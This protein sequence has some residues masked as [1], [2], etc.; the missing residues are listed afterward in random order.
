MAEH[1]RQ[2][3][4]TP[5]LDEIV[6]Y[7]KRTGFVYPSSEI[8]G[9]FAGVYDYG[10]RGVELINNIKGEWW[11][12]VVRR[13]T[14][15]V[16]LDASIFMHPKTWEAS[17]HVENFSDPLTECRSCNSRLR[18][19]HML[20]GIGV[21]ADDK[22][23][24][25]EITELFDEHR[26]EISCPH[27]DAK[28]FT[29]VRQF[30]LLV[31]SNMGNFTGDATKDPVWLRGE[32]CQGIY[33][34]YNN[35]VNTSRVQVPFGIAQIGKAF[36]NEITARQFIF[37]TRE[38]EQMENQRF[39]HPDREM[40]EYERLRDE[41]MEYYTRRLGFNGLN[42]QWKEHDKLAFYANAAW[43]IEYRYPFGFSE[44]EGVHAR[45]NYDLTQHSTHSGVDLSYRDPRTNE[46][47]IPHVIES[48][49]GVGRTALAALTDAY[50]VEELQSGDSRT[51][52]KLHPNLAP[53]K[54][55]V[56]PLVRNKP[57]IVGMAKNIFT[58]ISG[59]FA[60]EFD[61][62]G[63]TGKR[64]RR[65]DEIGTPFAITVDHESVEDGTV[66]VRHRDTMQ[67]ERVNASQ[68]ED[69]IRNGLKT[70]F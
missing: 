14:D 27:C 4:D 52:L 61:D 69:Y 46:R 10:P 33:V 13:R 16:G 58:D 18:V 11:K 66:T 15:T 56:F 20:E 55:A 6:G 5:S 65:Q 3:S 38:F 40:E 36:R 67:Q 1:E 57:E 19:D 63:N 42:L 41:R 50:N 49:T 53:V 43:D 35:V 24:L 51:V 45:G 22:M 47:Y 62:N 8:Y 25:D 7:S 28:D 60:T 59:E 30:N 70:Q 48:S 9:G 29:D 37:R 32:T 54:A 68:L 39:V 21:I 44:L 64:Y 12:E 23:T 2:Q 31:A 34:D 26:D 17:G